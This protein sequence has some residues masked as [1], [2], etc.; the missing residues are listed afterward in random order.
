VTGHSAIEDS[1]NRNGSTEVE[2]AEALVIEAI[3]IAAFGRL[4]DVEIDGVSPGLNVIYGPNE[5]GKSTLYSFFSTMLFG[6]YPANPEQHPYM[7]EIGRHLVGEIQYT[8]RGGRRVTVE[9]KLMSSPTGTITVEGKSERLGQATLPEADFLSRDVYSSVFALTLDDLVAPRR[10]PGWEKIQDRLLGGSAIDSLRSSRDVIAD[11]ES[12]ASSLW[13]DSN[14]GKPR[15]SEIARQIDECRRDVREATQR[16]E[17]VRAHTDEL[18][19]VENDLSA[20]VDMK[21]AVDARLARLR[22]VVP[23]ERL[24]RT[25]DECRRESGDV[26]RFEYVPDDPLSDLKA[27]E[28]EINEHRERLQALQS[29][30]DRCLD[31]V[32]APGD[33]DRRLV[34]SKEDIRRW[35]V[36]CGELRRDR[37]RLRTE[38]ANVTRMMADRESSAEVLL[39]S[40]WTESAGDRLDAISIADLRAAVDA[41]IRARREEDE[42]RRRPVAHESALQKISMPVLWAIAGVGFTLFIAGVIIGNAVVAAVGA[43]A[44]TFAGVR[45]ADRP[46]PEHADSVPQDAIAASSERCADLRTKVGAILSGLDVPEERLQ[47][48]DLSL[49]HDIETLRARHQAVQ[50]AELSV[51]Q[52]QREVSSTEGAFGNFVASLDLAEPMHDGTDIDKRMG[53]LA[54]LCEA[55]SQRVGTGENAREAL[56]DL[57][58]AISRLESGIASFEK[59]ATELRTA[60][61]D[62]GDGDI[63]IGSTRLRHR[64][65]MRAH[66][67]AIER[68]IRDHSGSIADAVARVDEAKADDL[69]LFA[70]EAESGLESER[71]HLEGELLEKT[72]RRADLKKDIDNLSSK[73]SLADVQGELEQLQSDLY[74]TKWERDRLAL[75][76]AVV[77]FADAR[78]RAE[79]QPDVIRRASVYFESMTGG[80]YDRISIDGDSL[81]VRRAADERYLDLTATESRVSRGTRDQLYL[82]L[83]LA[84]I[85]HLDVSHTRLPVFLDEVLVNWDAGRRVHGLRTIGAMAR[86]RQVFLFTCHEWL[87]DEAVTH[88]RA[89]VISIT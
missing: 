43:I 60:L 84:L 44:T 47:E 3:R 53:E 7:P 71:S 62:V 59:K 12:G 75:A 70:E 51:A 38:S 20:L 36:H 48:P 66:A 40:G 26:D 73:P 34:E 22:A 30:R 65:E 58:E 35:E 52:L 32:A 64:R 2:S 63:V 85:D 21:R 57:E 68:Q 13:R 80:R 27:A 6:V 86:E 50:N 67:R 24:L 74:D 8:G 81:T 56:V 83:R 45:L 46:P 82:A 28:R 61:M 29:R 33:I 89:N 19:S 54:R 41:Y 87:R 18:T 39:S 31:A 10:T 42:L 11:F 16:G 17:A 77:R 72:G 37:D 76:A 49:V 55:A 69:E 23:I 5:A 15:A 25:L 88:T 78:F 4:V 79:H 1:A 9:R 14:R